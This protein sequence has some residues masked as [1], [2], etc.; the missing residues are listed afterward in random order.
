METV[1]F[2]NINFQLKTQGRG[3]GIADSKS[4]N[5][6]RKVTCVAGGHWKCHYTCEEFSVEMIF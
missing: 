2:P 4:L 5:A 6:L 1:T 3:K